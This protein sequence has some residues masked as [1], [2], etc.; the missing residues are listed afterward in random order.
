MGLLVKRREKR[1]CLLLSFFF[2]RDYI[3]IDSF[4]SQIASVSFFFLVNVLILL[5]TFLT[6]FFPF[7]VLPILLFIISLI[8]VGNR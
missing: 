1:A 7:F 8:S 5:A 2:S 6:S 4:T 3:Y